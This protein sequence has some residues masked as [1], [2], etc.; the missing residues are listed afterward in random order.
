MGQSSKKR[1]S[2]RRFFFGAIARSDI[3]FSFAAVSAKEKAAS[4]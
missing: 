4:N 1:L 2:S 3:A